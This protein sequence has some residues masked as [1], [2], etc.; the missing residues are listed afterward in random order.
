[1]VEVMNIANITLSLDVSTAVLLKL[2]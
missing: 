1:M 2:V